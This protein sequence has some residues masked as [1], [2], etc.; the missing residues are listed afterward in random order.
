MTP[1]SLKFTNLCNI[2]CLI[3]WSSF[4]II[5][6]SFVKKFVKVLS[7]GLS[8]RCSQKGV[9]GGINGGRSTLGMKSYARNLLTTETRFGVH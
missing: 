1:L 7:V 3:L 5:A 9:F 4:V 2:L 6:L 8:L